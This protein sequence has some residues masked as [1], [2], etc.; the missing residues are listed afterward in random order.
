MKNNKCKIL[1]IDDQIG[2]PNSREM[3]DFLL[4]YKELVDKY[5]FTFETCEDVLGGYSSDNAVKAI[6]DNKSVD[7][8]LLDIKFGS[9]SDRL[10]F[11]ILER[12]RSQF[13]TIP[14]VVMSSL[15]RDV[16]S[17]S[18]SLEPGAIS[19]VSKRPNP[20]ALEKKI[21]DAF[22]IAK[23]YILLGNSPPIRTLR[24]EIAKVSPY[25]IVPILIVGERGTGKERVARNIHHN[26]PRQN[27]SFVGINCAGLP[28][29]IIESELFG[30]EKGAFTG[31]TSMRKGYFEIAEGG[32]LF[33]DEIGEIPV[34]IQVKL[35]RVLEERKFRR[36]GV[37]G[38]DISL[39]VQLVS[40]T[41][42]DPQELISK[43][44]MREDFYDRVAA[45]TI[46]TPPLRK[47]REDIPELV[48]Y[49]LRQLVHGQE[50][51]LATETLK[52]L[53]LY[54]WP[55]NGRELKNVIWQAV[56]KSGDSPIIDPDFLP[57]EIQKSS[58]KFEENEKNDS[59]I[60]DL[61][62]LKGSYGKADLLSYHIL[63]II[64]EEEKYTKNNSA[65]LIRNLFP[66]QK[67]SKRYLGQ[68]GWK[69]VDWN[70]RILENPELKRLFES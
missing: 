67:E 18:R 17:L 28:S 66:G 6:M 32:V 61:G 22:N 38:K 9:E 62:I 2:K 65:A 36:L 45:F 50:K 63:K 31:A 1:V 4:D 3:N 48:E 30:Y 11:E 7:L 58:S 60:E 47:Y 55:G 35:L 41:N 26:G 29:S 16:E 69:L 52:L 70:P 54:H 37:S 5:E 15:E 19:F 33:L 51:R 13:S 43:G 25:D 42:T 44:K 34:E 59:I 20:E 68:I 57:E 53:K 12:I 64:K 8:V 23:D 49:F 10:G 27:G 39:N 40:A 21:E 14:V 46:K 24:R 56:I